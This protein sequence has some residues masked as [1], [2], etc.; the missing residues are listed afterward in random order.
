VTTTDQITVD[1]LMGRLTPAQA[2]QARATAKALSMPT[3]PAAELHRIADDLA[4]V[5]GD[6]PRLY[7][8]LDVSPYGQDLSDDAK[9]AVVDAVATALLGVKADTRQMS[10]GGSWHHTAH[11]RRGP[12]HL[13]VCAAVSDPATRDK[14]AE[15]ERLRAE[16]TE[17]RRTVRAAGAARGVDAGWGRRTPPPGPVMVPGTTRPK[18]A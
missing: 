3:E 5:T 4:S 11:G 2:G 10:A 12:V 18:A 15:L 17:L 1:E 14:D 13:S 8:A 7:L 6:L 9:T 16:N